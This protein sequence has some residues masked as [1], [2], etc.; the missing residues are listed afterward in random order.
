MKYVGFSFFLPELLLKNVFVNEGYKY[1][2]NVQHYIANYC[3]LTVD[4]LVSHWLRAT[5]DGRQILLCGNRK[6]G[7]MQC[8]DDSMQAGRGESLGDC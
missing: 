8:L 7:L 6:P 2:C 3:Q 1:S 5:V 4:G